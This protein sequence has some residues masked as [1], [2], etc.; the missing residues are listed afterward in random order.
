MRRAVRPLALPI[1]LSLVV[2]CE[3]PTELTATASVVSDT[4]AVYALTGTDFSLPSAINFPEMAVVRTT[5]AFNFD[6]GFDIRS[7]GEI[8]LYPMTLLVAEPESPADPV[9]SAY[10][11]PVGLQKVEGTFA[12]LT[13]APD[14]GY[15]FD[16]PLVVAVGDVVAVQVAALIYCG[17]PYPE[18][19]YAKLS[20]LEIEPDERRMRVA[21]TVDPS[22]GFRSF[23]P[24]IPQS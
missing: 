20:V 12:E 10:I 23:L 11:H 22:C 6:V 2:A 9:V 3:D 17:V 1:A 5:G 19:I 13:R 16:E 18:T 8:V 4:V 14:A 7:T 21:V 24:G 15:V